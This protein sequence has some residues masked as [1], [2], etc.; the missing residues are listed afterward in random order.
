[1]VG[2][3]ENGNS[4]M[5]H[6]KRRQNELRRDAEQNGDK[7]NTEAA[8]RKQRDTVIVRTL[9]AE[10]RA[11]S[12]ITLTREEFIGCRLNARKAFLCA[13]AC[14]EG[15]IGMVNGKATLLRDDYC[16]GLGDCLPTCPTGA[17]TFVE[18]E[19]AAYDEEALE[20]ISWFRNKDF[21][22]LA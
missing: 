14:H 4:A 3:L 17:I 13:G 18:R 7:C 21:K 2:K 15:A 12:D 10:L 19:A 16:D 9:D 1:M 8:V 22:C 11:L 5:R 6:F 20:D